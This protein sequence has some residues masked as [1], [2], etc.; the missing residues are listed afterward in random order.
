MLPDRGV[1]T[2]VDHRRRDE[3]HLGRRRAG[4]DRLD[5]RAEIRMALAVDAR[6][7]EIAEQRKAPRLPAGD[8][9]DRRLD[10]FQPMQRVVAATMR[11]LQQ[12][13]LERADRE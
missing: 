9:R 7:R 2:G 1:R 13:R 12:A 5:Q 4:L 11:P 6:Q 3:H 10:P 8:G